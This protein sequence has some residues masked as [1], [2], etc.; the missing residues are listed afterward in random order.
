MPESLSIQRRRVG[1]TQA[2]VA[3]ACGLTQPLVSLAERGRASEALTQ[4]IAQALD[5]ELQRQA[6]KPPT[7][8]R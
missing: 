8:K 6:G 5:A 4:R 2:E 1:W 3:Q 7:R